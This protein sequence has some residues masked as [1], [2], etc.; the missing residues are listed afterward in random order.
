MTK[1]EL[2]EHIFEHIKD[3]YW[4]GDLQFLQAFEDY[5]DKFYF[6]MSLVGKEELIEM[7]YK[8]IT[9]LRDHFEE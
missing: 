7:A 4:W 9:F 6:N 2:F 8:E 5:I 1:K 3:K